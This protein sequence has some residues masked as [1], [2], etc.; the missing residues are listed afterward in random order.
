MKNSKALY[1]T[2]AA[3]TAAVYVVLTL[4]SNVFGLSSGP[5]QVRISEALTILPYY[6]PEAVPG[7]FVGCLLSNIFTGCLPWDVV[8]GSLATLLGALGT[9]FVARKFRKRVLAIIPPVLANAVIIPFIL[10]YVYHLPKAYFL[11]VLLVGIGELISCS[12]GLLLSHWG[13]GKLSSGSVPSVNSD[14]HAK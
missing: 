2:R 9:R 12:I 13:R 10:Q 3:M 4:I 7:L 5:V 8:F 6:L 14:T 1:I 11:L